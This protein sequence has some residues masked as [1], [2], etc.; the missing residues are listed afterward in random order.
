M[1]DASTPA[2]DGDNDDPAFVAEAAYDK[3]MGPFFPSPNLLLKDGAEHAAMREPWERRMAGLPNELK[4]FIETTTKTH[5]ESLAAAGEKVGLYESMKSLSWNL[6]LGAFLGLK[7]ADSE[8]IIIERLQEQLLRGQFSLFPVSMN[9]GFWHSPRKRGIEARKSLQKVIL[10]RLRSH[11]KSACPFAS[12]SSEA[13]SDDALQEIADHVL[14][15]ASSLAAKALASL[16]TAV[17][18]NIHLHPS[19]P[20]LKMQADTAGMVD[21]NALNHVVMETERLSPPIVGVMRRTTRETELSVSGSSANVLL[22]KGWDVWLYFVGG[23]RDAEAFGPDCDSFKPV[24]YADS[25]T[26]KPLAF[27]AG[28]KTCLG[29]GFTRELVCQVT[30]TCLDSGVRM[31]GSVK[32]PGV[33]AWLGWIDNQ[34]VTPEQWAADVSQLPTQHSAQPIIVSFSQE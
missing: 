29:H 19:G 23:G 9:T 22:P 30:K 28:A 16:L 18:L 4:S 3:L 26:P 33:Q 32:A 24:R 1:L 17:F 21:I 20:G 6:L 7:P 31:T 25:N 27:G 10:E 15:F 5:F 12:S 34:S 13:G 2:H 14:L 11:G 8:F